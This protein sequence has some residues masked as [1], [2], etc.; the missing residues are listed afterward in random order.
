MEPDKVRVFP[1]REAS[2][3][4]QHIENHLG[5]RG[6]P[7]FVRLAPRACIM[8]DGRLSS[9]VDFDEKTISL[10]ADSFAAVLPLGT[11]E[12][13]VKDGQGAPA[14]VRIPEVKTNALAA[15]SE[16]DLRVPISVSRS[17]NGI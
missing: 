15:A 4:C 1:N 10:R 8:L 5:C 9:M 12:A 2:L 14:G 11:F 3:A 7:Q 17:Y 16:G 13:L 6:R